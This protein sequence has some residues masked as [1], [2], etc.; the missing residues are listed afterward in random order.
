M[1][2][3][4]IPMKTWL[5]SPNMCRSKIWDPQ[6][7]NVSCKDWLKRKFK[8]LH[9]INLI[10]KLSLYHIVLENPL[11]HSEIG[12]KEK[13]MEHFF[14][15]LRTF[16]KTFH[17]CLSLCLFIFVSV[18]LYFFMSLCQRFCQIEKSSAHAK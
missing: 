14:V 8:K 2:P 10:N 12:A 5:Y 1:F 6:K 3:S 15:Y 9:L 17:V 11:K 7:I 13:N 18:C 4:L 16:G